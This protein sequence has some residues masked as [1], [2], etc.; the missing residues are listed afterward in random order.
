M[1]PRAA[2]WLKLSGYL[3]SI[4]SVGLIA[5]PAWEHAREQPVLFA[6]LVAG[7]LASIVGQVMRFAANLIDGPKQR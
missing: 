7:G 4:V 2:L 5:V 3:V 6:C 1:T